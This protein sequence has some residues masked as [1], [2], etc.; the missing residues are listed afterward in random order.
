MSLRAYQNAQ[1]IL[2]DPREIEYRLFGEV[3]HALL[4]VKNTDAKG[5]KLIEALDWNRRVWKA[6]GDDCQNPNNKLPAAVRAQI[7]TISL[8]VGRY[9][10][11]VVRKHAS[12]DPLIEVNR[13]IMQGLQPPKTGV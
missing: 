7:I 1:R 13:S 2:E 12:L 5:A 8:W 9:T 4:E 3:T 11:K 6:M 10:R